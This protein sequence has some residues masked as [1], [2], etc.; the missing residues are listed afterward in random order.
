MAENN[1]PQIP[2]PEP[3]GKLIT[4]TIS[5]QGPIPPPQVLAHYDKIV[6]GA[7]QR[8]L[9]LA[10][11]QAH[12]RQG[13]ENKIVNI[14]TRGQIFGFILGFITIIG[15]FIVILSGKSLEGMAMV[16]GSLA[17]LVGVY[18]YARKQEK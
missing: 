10:E 3:Q 2:N 7:A 9:Q 12:H 11:G 16:I 6:P 4:H 18:I 14:Q 1:P 8:L 15:G 5:Y 17:S 13:I